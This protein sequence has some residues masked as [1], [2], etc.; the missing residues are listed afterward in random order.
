L[1]QRFHG[2]FYSRENELKLSHLTSVK[3]QH[4]DT[5]VKQQHDESVVDY[6]MRFRD[7]KN[8]CFS[9]T[10]S[11]KDLADLTFNGLRSYVKEKLEGHFFTSVNQVLDRAL[12]QENRSKELAKSKSNHPNIHF[13]NNNVDT[14][15]DESGDVY[16]AEFAWSSKDKT[17]TYA[18]LKSIHRNRR[19]EIKFTF[20]VSKCDKIFDELLS[21]GKIK[22]S[23]TIPSIEDLK[24][25]DYCK[26]HNSYSHTTNDCNVFRRQIQLAINEGQLCL[27]QMQVDNDPFP[28]SVI[29]LQGA[30][31]LVQP[32]QAESTKGKNVIIDEERPKSYEDKIWSR[33]V[34]LEKDADGNDVL[35]ITIKASGLREQAGNSK[36]DRSSV[37]QKTQSRS[38][39]PK[40]LKPKNPEM[41]EWKVVN[42][43]VKEKL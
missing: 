36:K 33:E 34:V 10:I 8:R 37:Q 24:K 18:S 16:A 42:V 27:K 22:L 21:I 35:K 32:E 23:H 5:S 11:D 6:I 3:Q 43:K 38:V 4:D 40:M 7:T 9:L 25:R 29:D 31:V 15:D 2:H 30:K 26:W 1:E 39:R 17:H 14:S 13:L 41:D 12:A 28:V 19:D 20:V